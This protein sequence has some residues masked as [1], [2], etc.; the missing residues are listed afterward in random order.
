MKKIKFL[1]YYLKFNQDSIIWK[2]WV[3]FES[4]SRD[5][6]LNLKILLPS[7][8]TQK[9]IV[10]EIEILEKEIKVLREEN[11]AIPERKKEIL[12]KYL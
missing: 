9:K 3:W 5:E 12:T 4:I 1:Y 2:Q 7:L 6:I 11:K 10:A 8:E